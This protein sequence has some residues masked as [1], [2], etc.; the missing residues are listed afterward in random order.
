MLALTALLKCWKWSNCRPEV[1]QSRYPTEKLSENS[2]WV[3]SPWNVAPQLLLWNH[4]TSEFRSLHSFTQKASGLY[5]MQLLLAFPKA[6]QKLLFNV[7]MSQTSLASMA[8]HMNPLFNFPI[9]LQKIVWLCSNHSF[10]PEQDNQIISN[11]GVSCRVTPIIYLLAEQQNSSRNLLVSVQAEWIRLCYILIP[12]LQ[13]SESP[14]FY[15]WLCQ[16]S[17][18]WELPEWPKLIV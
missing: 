1:R 9:P 12:A 8:V 10:H 7:K 4:F 13:S 18:I 14:Y 15:F 11:H 2:S 6:S 16:N 17:A 3:N 5:G